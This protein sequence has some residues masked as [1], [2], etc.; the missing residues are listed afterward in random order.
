M[1]RIKK[2]HIKPYLYLTKT[3]NK[4]KKLTTSLTPPPLK[5][6]IKIKKYEVII[7]VNS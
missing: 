4:K 7:E 5:H 2:K 3:Y 1:F 6:I